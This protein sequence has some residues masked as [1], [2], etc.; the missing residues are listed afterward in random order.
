MVDSVILALKGM[1]ADTHSDTREYTPIHAL[2]PYEYDAFT[3]PAPSRA[4]VLTLEIKGYTDALERARGTERRTELEGAID[5]DPRQHTGHR[6][7][8][9]DDAKYFG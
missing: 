6:H 1:T 2:R 4:E 9:H 5:A 3:W 8:P 7:N